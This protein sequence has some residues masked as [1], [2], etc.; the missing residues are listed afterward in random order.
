MIQLSH[1][2]RIV[3]EYCKICGFAYIVRGKD[4]ILYAYKHKP[5]LRSFKDGVIWG[6]KKFEFG[7]FSALCYGGLFEFITATKAIFN[8]NDLELEEVP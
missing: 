2:E 3:I 1:D 5:E 8:V 7:C 6:V 4:D